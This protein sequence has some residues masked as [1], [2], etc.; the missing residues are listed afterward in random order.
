[1][2]DLSHVTGIFCNVPDRIAADSPKC[3]DGRAGWYEASASPNKAERPRPSGEGFGAVL[4]ILFP[5]Y[6]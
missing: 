2:P 6:I 1:M 5:F 4:F 3:V